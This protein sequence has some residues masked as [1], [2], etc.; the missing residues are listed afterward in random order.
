MR[1]RLRLIPRAN[2]IG[3]ANSY[4]THH[5][6]PRPSHLLL[7]ER[8]T[9][10]PVSRAERRDAACSFTCP[11]SG[12]AVPR[13]SIRSGSAALRLPWC[14]ASST[15]L[16]L[17]Q[18]SHPLF[19]QHPESLS[20]ARRA[21]QSCGL[22][23]LHL[24]PTAH[25]ILTRAIS[26]YFSPWRF[27]SGNNRAVTRCLSTDVTASQQLSESDAISEAESSDRHDDALAWAT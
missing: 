15:S 8:A 21:V 1:Q 26:P 3:N 2:V 17:R 25:L 9:S 16:N 24:A 4:S 11:L 13:R 10:A 12:F 19:R 6:D 20:P 5:K 27:T 7:E 22:R 14:R 18:H 23:P